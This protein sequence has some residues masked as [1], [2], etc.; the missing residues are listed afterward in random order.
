MAIFDSVDYSGTQK[1]VKVMPQVPQKWS[2]MVQND[3]K[4]H[5]SPHPHGNLPKIEKKI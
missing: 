1:M 2:K 5:F 3:Q 4:S